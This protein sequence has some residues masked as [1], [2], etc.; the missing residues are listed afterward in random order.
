MHMKYIFLSLILLVTLFLFSTQVSANL[1]FNGGEYTNICGSGTSA[2]SN[3]CNGS[4]NATTGNCSN[5]GNTVIRFV[6]DGRQTQCN[7]NESSFSSSQSLGNP[8]AN[9]TVA[10][11]VFNKTCRVNGAWSCGDSDMKD[12]MVWYSGSTNAQTP[13]FPTYAP[14]PASTTAPYAICGDQQPVLIQFQKPNASKWVGGSDFT[15]QNINA[16][17]QVNVNCF[18]KNGTSLLTNGY[19]DVTDPTNHTYR[20]SNTSELRN[21]QANQAG[22][23]TFICRSS[24]LNNCTSQDSFKTQLPPTYAPTY[25]PTPIPTPT[26]VAAQVSTCN[27]L[28][29]VG[30]QNSLVP[31]TVTLRAIGADNK[32]SIQGYRYYFGDGQQV[33][34]TQNETQHQ[35]ATSGSFIARADVKDS[36]GNWKTSTSCETTVTVK[37][38]SIESFRSGCSDI[39]IVAD[40]NSRAP[41]KVT[42]EVTGYDNKGSLKNYRLDFGNGVVKESSGRNFEQLYNSVGT[43]NVKA[44]VQDSQGNWVGGVNNCNRTV[45]IGSSKPLTSQP[46]TGTPTAIPVAGAIS[47]MLGLSVQALKKRFAP[48]IAS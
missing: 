36:Q 2:N 14:T 9:K 48:A 40:N 17:N 26:P 27:S 45:V 21:F 20:A 37:P 31:A 4:C 15:N 23:Y 1:S 10:I 32:G 3:N 28:Q 38:V 6:C 8:G 46:S 22:N 5:P 33:E 19:I 29:V 12:Y 41:S 44:Y 16:G 47:G 30:G 13:V 42:F 24:S 25:A 7:Q 11:V 39:H 34:T 43:Y 18:S 35:Y